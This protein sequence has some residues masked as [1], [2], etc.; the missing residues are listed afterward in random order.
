M[1]QRGRCPTPRP[2][3]RG[4]GAEDRRSEAGEGPLRNSSTPL[5]ARSFAARQPLPASRGEGRHRPHGELRAAPHLLRRFD[6][7]RSFAIS[8]SIVIVLP[9]M[10]LSK[11]HCG[12]KASCSIGAKRAAW[13]IRRFN[14]S[15]DSIPACGDQAEHRDL[16]LGQEAQRLEAAGALAV[17]FEEIAVDV[18]RVEQEFGDRL[19]APL[20]PRPRQNC[21]G[22]DACTPSCR[23]AGRRSCRS[24]ASHRSS[25][26]KP[27]PRRYCSPARAAPGRTDRRGS[28]RRSADSGIPPPARSE[29]SSRR[30]GEIA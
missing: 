3:K 7:S 11:P 29:I 13:S 6:D 10:P 27:D 18:D 15:L 23:P 4:E 24:A 28:P 22:R 25:A 14:S 12:L 8:C 21:R 17:V 9:P 16:A 5:P 26:A 19:V 20:R 2:A 1:A 30:R